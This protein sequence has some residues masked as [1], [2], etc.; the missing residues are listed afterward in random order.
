MFEQICEQMEGWEKEIAFLT[1]ELR[2]KRQRLAEID[3]R[4]ERLSRQHEMGILDDIQL[5]ERTSEIAWDRKELQ[6]RVRDLE[7]IL[8]SPTPWNLGRDDSLVR[9]CLDAFDLH[10][11]SPERNFM[12]AVATI[13]AKWVDDLGMP[14]TLPQEEIWQRIAE[15]SNLHVS[16]YPPEENEI[17]GQRLK[18]TLRITGEFSP[19]AGTQVVGAGVQAATASTP[20]LR[21]GQQR[22][23]STYV[24]LRHAPC[25]SQGSLIYRDLPY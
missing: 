3:H 25:Q 1:A 12:S 9:E 8:S 4:L 7:N 15:K 10:E 5:M 17:A 18:A 20:S 14:G 6:A 13:T 21:H 11:G 24:G 19:S 22:H 2:D 23:P 16:I